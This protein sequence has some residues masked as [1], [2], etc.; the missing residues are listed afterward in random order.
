MSNKFLSFIF[1]FAF[2]ILSFSGYPQY[3]KYGTALIKNYKPDD[4]E[5]APEIYDIVQS[6]AGIVYF[7]TLGNIIEYDGVEW[8]KIPVIPGTPVLALAI[9]EFGTIY[10]SSGKDFGFI[11]PDKSG[12]LKY[13]SLSTNLEVRDVNIENIG[14]VHV[15]D[16]GIYFQT[17]H[18]IF[19]YKDFITRTAAE[20]GIESLKPIVIEAPNAF[21]NTYSVDNHLF[22]LEEK[23]GLM[24][25]KG[26]ELENFKYRQFIR[27]KTVE[28]LPFEEDKVVVCTEKGIYFYKLGSGFLKFDAETDDYLNE[29]S[30][31]SATNL[32]EAFAFATINK[33]T[34]VIG[35]KRVGKKR[36]IVEQYSKRAGLP[37]EQITSIYN[38]PQ[39]DEDL[40]WLSSI[41]GISLTRLNSPLRK[42]YE[43]TAVSDIIQDMRWHDKELFVRTLGSIYYMKDTLDAYLFTKIKNISANTD[44]TSFPIE[45]ETEY[46]KKRRKWNK[47]IKPITKTQKRIIVATRNGLYQIANYKAEDFDLEKT[48]YKWETKRSGEIYK[49]QKSSKRNKGYTKINSIFRS[50]QKPHRIYLGLENGAAVISYQQG[51]WLNEGYIAGVKGEISHVH[52]CSNG[53]VWFV[54]KNKGAYRVELNNI[55]V[56]HKERNPYSKNWRDSISYDLFPLSIKVKYYNDS[57]GLPIMLEQG[58]YKF[59]DKLLFA[60][61]MGLYKFNRENEKFEKYKGLGNNLAEGTNRIADFAL[62]KQENCWI[63]VRSDYHT[64]LEFFKKDSLGNYSKIEKAFSAFPQMTIQKIFPDENGLVWISGSEGLFVY[65]PEAVKNEQ[66]KKST[67]IRK[68]IIGEDSIL[69]G[70]ANFTHDKEN[71]VTDIAYSFISKKKVRLKYDFNNITFYYAAP[72]FEN[73]ESIVFSHKLEG[74]EKEWT[75]W[76]NE[77]YKEYS[78]L[79]T[80]KY[81]F[82]VKAKDASEKETEIATFYFEIAPPWYKTWWAY[83][84][85]I[86][87]AGFLIWSFI[88]LYTKRLRNEKE[89]LEKIVDDRTKEIRHQKEEI[90]LQNDQIKAGITYASRIQE[91]MLPQIEEIKKQLPEAFI[92]LNP[93]DVVSGDFYW[94]SFKDNKIFIAAV[95]CTGHGVPGAFMS[96]IGD[97]LLNQIVNDKNIKEPH[98][99]LE[100]LHRGV[101]VTL[102]QNETDNRDGMDMT[103]CAIDLKK[104]T[105]EFAGAKNPMV[106]IQDGQLHQ[107]KGDRVAI[108]GLQKESKRIFTKHKVD[109]SKPT[110]VYLFSDGFQDQFGGENGDKYMSG[111]FKK[112]LHKIHN[113]PAEKQKEILEN[114]FSEWKGIKYEQLDDVLVIGF[115]L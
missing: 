19:W 85:Y 76:H 35:K 53:D 46:S 4:Y 66:I 69:F 47:R 99:I 88:K 107:I 25:L 26:T 57:L 90:E 12:F 15:N 104:K 84:I 102:K 115:K 13:H 20:A 48:V 77:N 65:D 52:E 28:I 11:H 108:G 31:L 81:T 103:I 110:W 45:V 114:T 106:Y 43:A 38:N 83:T 111:N 73:N 113:N 41:Y 93:K 97:S 5:A 39:F 112:L 105:L 59:K 44:W 37:T 72:F 80:G 54:E 94:H 29:I 10:C 14:K 9:D 68:I 91:A 40:L 51:E 86:I 64:G 61:Q 67:F 1:V 33:G 22:V 92:L 16:N 89:R 78:N 55:G 56:A 79:P 24:Q 96:M 2:L 17:Y 18:F 62:D 3:K 63:S 74:L 34:V 70:G 30:I 21:E 82:K 27:R 42:M 98:K 50:E 75:H 7:A 101:R 6:N 32:P 87:L 71:Q 60:T 23:I 36:R 100:F 109:V 58:I 95:D 8:R 49:I